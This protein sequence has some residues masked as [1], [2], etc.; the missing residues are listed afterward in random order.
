M[1]L[2]SSKKKNS[3]INFDYVCVDWI[4]T[5]GEERY[6]GGT[7]Y[8]KKSFTTVSKVATVNTNIRH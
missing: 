8:I 5:L 2:G 4:D 1:E 3:I 6:A 7:V